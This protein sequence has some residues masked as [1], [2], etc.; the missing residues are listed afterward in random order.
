MPGDDLIPA[1]RARFSHHFIMQTTKV[2]Q[3]LQVAIRTLKVSPVHSCS[4]A[5]RWG[6]FSLSDAEEQI[7]FH[8]S[9]ARLVQHDLY[10]SSLLIVQPRLTRNKQAL[11]AEIPSLV[12]SAFS[13]LSLSD[14][15]TLR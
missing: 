6:F 12:N 15:V 14:R 8:V 9:E 2:L 1:D 11:V 5:H 3:L 4:L 7:T 10:L 13:H